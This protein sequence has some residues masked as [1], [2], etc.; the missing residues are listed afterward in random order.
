MKAVGNRL[1]AYRESKGYKEQADFLNAILDKIKT[2]I[3]QGNLSQWENG[4]YMPSYEKLS[5]IKKAF[6]DLDIDY[7]ITGESNLSPIASTDQ[8]ETNKTEVEYWKRLAKF[9]EQQWL[10]SQ[11]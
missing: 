1:K 5:L 2:G 10:D 6:P 7:I 9:W 3:S 4:R 8:P 11:K